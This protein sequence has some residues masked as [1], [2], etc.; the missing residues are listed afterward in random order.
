MFGTI[1]RV[2]KNAR[3]YYVVDNRIKESLLPL[4]KINIYTIDVIRVNHYKLLQ[5]IHDNCFSTRIY[6]DY[7]RVYQMIDFKNYLFFV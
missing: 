1:D 7:W 5:E 2:N 6:S 4:I 3:V